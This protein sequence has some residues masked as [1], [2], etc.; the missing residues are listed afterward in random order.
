V[1]TG[2]LLPIAVFI[3][4]GTGYGGSSG[5]QMLGGGM[6][7]FVGFLPLYIIRQMGAGD[8]KFFALLGVWLG[9]L[10]LLPVW[11]VGSLLAGVHA[12]FVVGGRRQSQ[13]AYVAA[14]VQQQSWAQRYVAWRG[15]R[16]GIP[17][18]AYLAA[19]ALVTLALG[20]VLRS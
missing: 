15:T 5:W 1:L 10:G 13:L 9:P 14:W 20:D 6:L 12:L 3:A 7:G 4:T 17:Y 8:V 19:G 11:I 2:L 18:A 16:G